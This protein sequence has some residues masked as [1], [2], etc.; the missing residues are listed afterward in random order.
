[1]P[2]LPREPGEPDLAAPATQDD[3]ECTTAA[4]T[5]A[6]TAGGATLLAQTWDWQGDQRAACVLLRVRAPAS[7][8]S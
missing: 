1:M 7:P 2:E 6:A 4:A 3:G 8:R 5:G